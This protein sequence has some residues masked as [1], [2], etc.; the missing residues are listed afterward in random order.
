MSLLGHTKSSD[1]IFWMTIE[2]FIIQMRSLYICAVFDEPWVKFGPIN[3]KWTIQNS[4]GPA[5]NIGAQKNPHYGLKVTKKCTF[6]VSL[7]QQPISALKG[8]NYIYL[9]ALRNN[10]KRITPQSLTQ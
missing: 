2:D 6:F 9:K 7:S 10:G 1:G 8:K 4:F 3:G 5:N